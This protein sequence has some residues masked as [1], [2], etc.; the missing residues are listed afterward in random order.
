MDR[1]AILVAH[2]NQR[3]CKL[4]NDLYSEGLHADT[5]SLTQHRD[6]SYLTTTA[7]NGPHQPI[8]SIPTS[9]GFLIACKIL[10]EAQECGMKKASKLILILHNSTSTSMGICQRFGA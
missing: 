1:H 6:I 10:P 3:L 7:E 4:G 2:L 8:W 5:A 9:G